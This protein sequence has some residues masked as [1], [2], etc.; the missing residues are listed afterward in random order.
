MAH[1]D[2][3]VPAMVAIWHVW[4]IDEVRMKAG[5]RQIVVAVI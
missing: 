4:E 5:A 2:E 1:M 3:M